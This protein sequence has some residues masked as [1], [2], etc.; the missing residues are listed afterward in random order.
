MFSLS[1]Q[2]KVKV[3]TTAKGTTM[4]EDT[5]TIMVTTMVKVTVTA[6]AALGDLSLTPVMASP[7]LPLLLTLVKVQGDQLVIPVMAS[8]PRLHHHHLIMVN[9]QERVGRTTKM[10]T[11]GKEITADT[12]DAFR[13]FSL[14]R[15]DWNWELIRS[16]I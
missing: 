16:H 1:V 13:H 12:G 7:L 14:E 10:A 11:S 5:T 8:L 9:S 3:T 2:V 4:L 6:K 15:K